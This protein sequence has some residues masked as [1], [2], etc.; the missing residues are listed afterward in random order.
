MANLPHLLFPKPTTSTRGT[1][2]GR[3]GGGY[4]T[5]GQQQAVRIEQRLTALEQAWQRKEAALADGMIGQIPEMVLVMEIAGTMDD[6]F[7]AIRKTEGMEF[8][9]EY[10]GELELDDE[11][12]FYNAESELVTQPIPKRVFLSL[13][14]QAALAE[15]RSLWQTHLAGN[16]LPHFKG[17]Y[18]TL[19][20]VLA[21]I[22]PYSV[23]DR[24]LEP[25]IRE[26]LQQYTA[27][28]ELVNFEVELVYKDEDGLFNQNAFNAFRQAIQEA[29]GSIVQGSEL[30]IAEL[31]YHGLIAQAPAARFT[32]LSE[33]T[34]VSFLKSSAALAFRPVGQLVAKLPPE[35]DLPPAGTGSEVQPPAELGEPIAALFDGLPIANHV[36]LEGRLTIDD[37]D[38]LEENYLAEYRLHGTSMAS[39]I[40]HGD[41]NIEGSAIISRLYVRPILRL[42]QEGGRWSEKLPETRL[43]ADLL[44][45]AVK[46]MKEG[47]P[48]TGEAPSAPNIKVINLA[49]GDPDRP[50]L[51]NIG[52]WAKVLDWLSFKYNILFIVSSGNH[53]SRLTIP[54]LNAQGKP[55]TVSERELEIQRQFVIERNERRILSPSES[56][57]ALTVGA[58]NTDGCETPQ[59]FSNIKLIS[60]NEALPAPYSRVGFGFDRSVKPEILLPGGRVMGRETPLGREINIYYPDSIL[61]H[62]PGIKSAMPGRNG[63]TDAEGYSI[64]TSNA[65]ALATRQAVFLH[66]M[67]EELNA[68]NPDSP[69]PEEY[70]PAMIKSLLVHGAHWSGADSI[71]RDVL[72]GKV[73]ANQVK[74]HTHPFLGYGKV[75]ETISLFS[76]SKRVTILGHGEL[77]KEEAHEFFIPLPEVLNGVD[78]EK[79][80]VLTLAWISPLHFQ[81]SKYRKAHLFLEN[82]AKNGQT[83]LRLSQD[84]FDLKTTGNGTVQHHVLKGRGADAFVEG[85]SLRVKVNCKEDAP[86]LPKSEKIR[87][88]LAVTFAVPASSQIEVYEQIRV[89][90]EQQVRVRAEV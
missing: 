88:A 61:L 3:G 6:F 65:T 84:I 63:A 41:H 23:K 62:P 30:T 52:I 43:F 83:E 77:A 27:P 48:D 74:R 14:N 8:L 11:F 67:L 35:E 18:K 64:G 40:V 20:E 37:P 5:N 68:E 44:I 21:D 39:L 50:Y 82:M 10:D 70:F 36:R 78:V 60:E 13:A 22:R 26:Y 89:G 66:Q 25:G 59:E 45:R 76:T 29:G 71:Y 47:D 34:H 69:I 7:S 56:I 9:G 79:N 28:D 81:S 33:N 73:K 51:F 17:K 32:D 42:K 54:S 55:L 4:S 75:H 49:I 87:Y 72:T 31:H 58:T 53:V 57:N 15:L 19:F 16:K 80:I 38:G 12:E 85:A 46:R 24:F 90:I 1:L 86:A 2:S